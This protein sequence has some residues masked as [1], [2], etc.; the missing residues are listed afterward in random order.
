MTERPSI[1]QIMNT[2]EDMSQVSC[3][4]MEIKK[5]KKSDFLL[6]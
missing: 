6:H 4:N 5:K 3:F 1:E 2:V